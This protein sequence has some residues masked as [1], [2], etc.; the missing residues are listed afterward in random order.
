MAISL[1]IPIDYSNFLFNYL[2]YS[3][4]IFF[5]AEAILTAYFRGESLKPLRA[6]FGK[7]KLK[8]P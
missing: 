6:N 2:G 3:I 4:F 7:G 1:L 8:Q 5:N